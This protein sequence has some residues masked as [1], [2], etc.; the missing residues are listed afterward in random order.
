MSRRGIVTTNRVLATSIAVLMVT[1]FLPVRYLTWSLEPARVVQRLSAPTMSAVKAAGD[2]F[3]DAEPGSARDPLQGEIDDLRRENMRLRRDLREARRELAAA[4]STPT[5]GD[6]SVRRLPAKIIAESTSPVSA[7]LVARI[8]ADQGVRPGN[9]AVAGGSH[10]VGRV[11]DVD[12]SMCHIL[13]ITATGTG[14]FGVMTRP[15]DG[16]P[17]VQFQL[18]PMGDGTLRGLGY[19]ET[20]GP[21]QTPRRASV[22]DEVRLSDSA[23]PAHEGLIVG[24][25]VSEGSSESGPLRQVVTVEPLI[26]LRRIESVVIRV[27]ENGS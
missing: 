6:T 22:G 26:D 1:S 5:T 18:E 10:L 14:K 12:S 25:I 21:A 24:T 23:W 3:S 27:P 9:L 8:G 7:V 17:G 20:D 13:P 4:L 11:A 2:R 19:Y 16:G 15:D